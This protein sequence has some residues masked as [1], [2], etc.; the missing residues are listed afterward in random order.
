VQNIGFGQGATNTSNPHA[1]GSKLKHEE[2]QFPMV[3]P[4]FVMVNMERKRR[5]FNIMHTT[6]FYRIK[7]TIRQFIPK[8]L[9]ATVQKAY[10]FVFLLDKKIASSGHKQLSRQAS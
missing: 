2:M 1:V 9:F 5:V 6:P 7:S 3:H 10:R 8:P 4:E